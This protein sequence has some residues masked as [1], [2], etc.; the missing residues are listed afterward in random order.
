MRE[1]ARNR[2]AQVPTGAEAMKKILR[3]HIRRLDGKPRVRT[4]VRKPERHEIQDCFSEVE[5]ALQRIERAVSRLK[6]EAAY[7]A[8]GAR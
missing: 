1:Q 3:K 7:S 4:A 2:L 6:A 8:S 5:T